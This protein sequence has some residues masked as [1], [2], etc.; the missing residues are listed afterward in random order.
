MTLVFISFLT[1]VIFWLWIILKYDKFEREP[2]KSILFVLVTGGLISAFSAGIL[3]DL[4]LGFANHYVEKGSPINSG[5]QL[6]L[7]SCGFVGLNEET[8]KALATILLIR[9]MKGFNEPADALV[10]AMT[11]ALGFAVFENIIYSIK[12]GLA[13]FYIRQFNAV[14]L[15]MG[16]AA[17]WG[18][19]IAKVKFLHQGKYFFRVLPYVLFA[20]I[21]HA[22]YNYSTYL[23]I[24]PVLTVIILS[25]FAFILIRFATRKVKRYAEDGPFANRLFCHSCGTVNFPDE[26]VCKKCGEKFHLE[27]YVLCH[28]CNARVSK[29]AEA[30]PRCGEK[31][32]D[33]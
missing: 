28:K 23:I 2:L 27:F 5:I 32:G 17:I 13:T 10:Y 4:F 1:S 29:I 15:H 16:L 12:Y 7:L 18:M 8:L 11:V 14:P 31:F 21:I 6:S 24:Y 9:R 33:R 3:N 20:A 22:L 19:G 25:G 30:C 26:R